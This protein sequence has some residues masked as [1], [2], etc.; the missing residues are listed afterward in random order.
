MI[1]PFEQMAVDAEN[2]SRVMCMYT[3]GHKRYDIANGDVVDVI[4]F[5]GTHGL[6]AD[7]L[8]CEGKYSWRPWV[9][10]LVE[11]AYARGQISAQAYETMQKANGGKWDD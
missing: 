1:D 4:I 5:R 7:D 6:S 3:R 11:N 2:E 9:G 10:Q 8:R